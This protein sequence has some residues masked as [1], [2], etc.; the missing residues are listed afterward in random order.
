MW[1]PLT[2]RKEIAL[3]FATFQIEDIFA[4]EMLRP[5]EIVPVDV[6]VARTKLARNDAKLAARAGADLQGIRRVRPH[7]REAHGQQTGRVGVRTQRHPTVDPVRAD[8]RLP[9]PLRRQRH[10][11]AD[12]HA[13]KQRDGQDDWPD[14]AHLGTPFD[15]AATAGRSC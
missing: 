15:A 11:T 13:Q 5:T 1:V 14:P 9:Q 4:P 12:V 8:R 3:V 2:V 6:D 7:R 10:G